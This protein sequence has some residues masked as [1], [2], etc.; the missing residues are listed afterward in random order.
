MTEWLVFA[1]VAALAAAFIAWPREQ[2]TARSS[3]P[4]AEEL[5]SERRAIL[6]ELREIDDDVLAGRIAPEDRAEARRALAPQLRHVTEALRDLGEE[7]DA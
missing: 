6:A 3:R 7:R 4:E 5:R 1:I 2:D